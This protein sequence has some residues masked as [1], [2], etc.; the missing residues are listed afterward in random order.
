[1]WSASDSS[2]LHDEAC[3]GGKLRQTS[4]CFRSRMHERRSLS[5]HKANQH[6][7]KEHAD[8]N[9]T[10]AYAVL[11]CISR[12]ISIFYISSGDIINSRVHEDCSHKDGTTKERSTR[13]NRKKTFKAL[14]SGEMNDESNNICRQ[15][16]PQCLPCETAFGK[17]EVDRISNAG[18]QALLGASHLWSPQCSEKSRCKI[19]VAKTGV[20]IC[21]V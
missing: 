4:T 7:Y 20:Q 1:M 9:C 10:R 21:G 17:K 16:H 6:A 13:L 3:V 15:S 2:R 14:V 18:A 11:T 12:W 5:P 8:T 19:R